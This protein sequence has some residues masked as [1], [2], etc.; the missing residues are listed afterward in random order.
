M[1]LRLNANAIITNPENKILFIQ[2]KKGP[3][4]GRLSLPGGGIEP[5]EL[6]QEAVKRELLEETGINLDGPIKPFGFCELVNKNLSDHRLVILLDSQSG[7]DASESE[8]GT[9]YGIL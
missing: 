8:E 7:A 4:E 3:F 1:K 6:S 2:L 9:P 5:G